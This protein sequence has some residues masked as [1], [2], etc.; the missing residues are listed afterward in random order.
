MLTFEEA[1]L[2][3]RQRCFKNKRCFSC[4]FSRSVTCFTLIT[5]FAEIIIVHSVMLV[6]TYDCSCPTPP[7]CT[8]FQNPNSQLRFVSCLNEYTAVFR[9]DTKE[10]LEHNPLKCFLLF[11]RLAI[12]FF[13][14]NVFASIRTLLSQN[15]KIYRRYGCCWWWWQRWHRW[16]CQFVH[17]H[18][19]KLNRPTHLPCSAD[20]ILLSGKH[21]SRDSA[22]HHNDLRSV[23]A[24]VLLCHYHKQQQLLTEITGAKQHTFYLSSLLFPLPVYRF[25]LSNSRRFSSCK[26]GI[27]RTGN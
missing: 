22:G 15:L 19:C 20:R 7:F 21:K 17:S 11:L 1:H 24:E 13:Y 8:L 4:Y 23:R 2:F 25:F 6:R 9:Y 5:M 27:N 14:L 16:R 26:H 10:W 18:D 3:L 12:F